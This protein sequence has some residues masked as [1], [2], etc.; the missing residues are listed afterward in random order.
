MKYERG[1]LSKSRRVI[2][3]RGLMDTVGIAFSRQR[4]EGR[5][6]DELR[7]ARLSIR[8]VQKTRAGDQVCVR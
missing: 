2:Q 1:L 3:K 6:V 7:G 4:N 5:E 8:Y